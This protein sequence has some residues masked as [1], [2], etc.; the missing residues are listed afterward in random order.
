MQ[1]KE[2]L[3]LLATEPAAQEGLQPQVMVYRVTLLLELSSIVLART[4]SSLV[5]HQ[6]LVYL[7]VI[8]SKQASNLM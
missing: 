4:W 6:P 8:K 2:E 5:N 3:H 1:C 7:M